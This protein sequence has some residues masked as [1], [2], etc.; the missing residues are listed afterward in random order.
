[1]LCRSPAVVASNQQEGTELVLILKYIYIPVSLTSGH[2]F[3]V[4]NAILTAG[5]S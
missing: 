3:L 2:E 4:I 5:I 1:M